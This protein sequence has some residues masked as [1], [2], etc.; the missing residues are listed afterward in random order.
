AAP[1]RVQVEAG[2]Q[3]VP[4]KVVAQRQHVNAVVQAQLAGSVHEHLIAEGV[5]RLA[6]ARRGDD[7]AAAHQPAAVDILQHEEITLVAGKDHTLIHRR[8]GA[9]DDRREPLAVRRQGGD[10]HRTGKG[11]TLDLL[12][13][14]ESAQALDEHRRCYSASFS[15]A[16]RNRPRASRMSA[17]GM[18][19]LGARR[20]TS[21]PAWS[22]S[23]PSLWARRM[24]WPALP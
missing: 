18:I 16:E 22:T 11:Q 9:F 10:P 12:Q 8:F 3:A 17:S 21:G 2:Q 13:I 6:E 19:R 7:A 15:S 1:I 24:I 14:V 5:E 20:T 23:T 4:G